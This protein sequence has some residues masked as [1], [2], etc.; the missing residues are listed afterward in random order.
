MVPSTYTGKTQQVAVTIDGPVVQTFAKHRG[1]GQ[2]LSNTQVFDVP[3]EQGRF[4]DFKAQLMNSS[5][6]QFYIEVVHGK[7]EFGDKNVVLR[8]DDRGHWYTM[9][10]HL[11]DFCMAYVVGDVS[12]VTS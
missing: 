6:V 2:K 9:H 8:T 10:G 3:V 11:N 5:L 4:D 12:S 1:V 7:V